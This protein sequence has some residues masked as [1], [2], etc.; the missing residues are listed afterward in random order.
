MNI[1]LI[2]PHGVGKTALGKPAAKATKLTYY[3]LDN[4]RSQYFIKYGYDPR[5]AEH[6][7]RHNDM[8]A[9]F[10]YWKPFAIKTIE[11]IMPKKQDCL[12]DLGASFIISPTADEIQSLQQLAQAHNTKLILVLPSDDLATSKAI[13]TK[14]GFYN[15]LT[16]H[17][18]DRY[19]QY[20]IT[21]H[22]F[23][24]AG[25]TQAENTQRLID[26]IHHLKAY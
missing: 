9:L 15:E 5:Q 12:F 21:D 24:T 17:F 20:H 10:K 23:F 25:H 2:G 19:Q 7:I 11:E 16:E 18:L 3:S 8:I 4:A 13:L 14:Q 26:L 22:V 6:Y 1:A